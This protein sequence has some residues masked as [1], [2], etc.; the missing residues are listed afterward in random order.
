MNKLNIFN[1][2]K[3]NN[4]RVLENTAEIEVLIVYLITKVKKDKQ[5]NKEELFDL[6]KNDELIKCNS[7][8]YNKI[9]KDCLDVFYMED[10][11]LS[12]FIVILPPYIKEIGDCIY[13]KFKS[14]SRN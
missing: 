9:L 13:S 6:V 5:K 2:S 14:N 12:S 8:T 11:F 4:L 3:D 7:N 1:K 10:K